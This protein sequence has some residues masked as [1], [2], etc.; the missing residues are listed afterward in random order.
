MS[1]W[2]NGGLVLGFLTALF[3]RQGIWICTAA[4][5]AAV[6]RH[7]EEQLLFLRG[8]D[9]ELHDMIATI[10]EEELAHLSHAQGRIANHNVWSGILERTIAKSTDTVIWLSTWG[11][12]M[13]MVKELSASR[14]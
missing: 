6:H 4:V 3:G 1:L 5:E 11:D 9:H 7:M 8:R 2:G 13:R 10:Q 14:E 12:S